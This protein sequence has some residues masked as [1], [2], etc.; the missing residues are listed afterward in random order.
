[1]GR[2][3][4]EVRAF[5]AVEGEGSAMVASELVFT[6]ALQAVRIWRLTS[7]ELTYVLH[8]RLYFVKPE[9][10][11]QNVN[12]GVRFDILCEGKGIGFADPA[13]REL[14]GGIA[15]ASSLLDG[16]C[17]GRARTHRPPG[18]TSRQGN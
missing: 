2:F 4:I 16:C 8:L 12:E 17:I 10:I 11:L 3:A 7:G 14:D 5:G 1:M 6:L 13:A 9:A 18:D 15:E